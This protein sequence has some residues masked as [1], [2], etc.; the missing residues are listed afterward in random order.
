MLCVV[1]AVSSTLIL[2]VLC[3]Q[4]IAADV[5]AA[6]LFAD[7]SVLEIQ[8]TGPIDD[9]MSSK[10]ERNE[11]PFILTENGV[12]HPVKV[13]VR[14][15]SRVKVCSFPPLRIN[16]KK[17]QTEE[18]IFSG[19]NKLKLVT[20]C[21]NSAESEKNIL[22]EYAAYKIFNLISD[23]GYRVRLLHISYANEDGRSGD[24]AL[25]R[26]GFVVESSRELAARTGA[27][28]LRIEGVPRRS[29]DEGQAAAVFVFQYLIGNTDWSFAADKEQ[30]TCCH[31]GDLFNISSRFYYVP[32]DFD[33]AGLV[34][35]SYA[36]PDPALQIR[37]V[38]QRLYRG[39]C[40]APGITRTALQNLIARQD[41][42]L[43]VLR[44]IPGLSVADV[45]ATV[46]YLRQFF[47]KA[48]DED[49]LLESFARRCL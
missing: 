35:A 36:Y 30:D 49:E 46:A 48:E 20:H 5:P 44:D 47:D 17:N 25:Q 39:L 29:V 43:Q 23:V 32:Y 24:N 22:Q 12:Q 16:F 45:E 31:N 27:K 4:A 14:G 41:D 11:F 18:T 9:L 26:Y 7:D 19:Q 6:P 28:A 8:L 15:N 40:Q 37:K 21:G 38:T 33:L 34:D 10:K 2:I 3:L 42:V 13:R 1:R